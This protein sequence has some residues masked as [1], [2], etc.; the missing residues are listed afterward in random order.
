MKLTPERGYVEYLKNREVAK[1]KSKERRSLAFKSEWPNKGEIKFINYKVKYRPNLDLV[2]R[3][4][5]V[6]FQGGHKIGV[7][8]RTGSGKSTIMM[9]LLRIL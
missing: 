1:V 2:L 7:V 3:G 4:L 5:T 8:G 6:T 9:S